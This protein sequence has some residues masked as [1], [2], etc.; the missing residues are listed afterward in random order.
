MVG[1]TGMSINSATPLTTGLQVAEQVRAAEADNTDKTEESGKAG[2]GV[3]AE[4]APGQAEA[5]GQE[6]SEPAHIEQLREMIKQL[7]KQMAEE[8]KQL[9]MLMARKMDETTKLPMVIAK[10][11]SI[12][13]LSGQIQ[14]ATAQLLKALTESGGNSAGG[15]VSTQA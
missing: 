12:A 3:K 13:T 15:M 6:P 10:Q 4:G 5:A 8:Q 11:A 2:D 9:A 1:I 14:A 7:Q